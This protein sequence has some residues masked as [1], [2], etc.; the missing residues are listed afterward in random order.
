MPETLKAKMQEAET[1]AANWMF[2]G[3]EAKN[4]DTAEKYWAKAQFW[5]DR[6]HHYEALLRGWESW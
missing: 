2:R 3:N 1:R 5:Q 4:H 6:M